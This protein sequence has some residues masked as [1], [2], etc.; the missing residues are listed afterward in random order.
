MS[1]PALALREGGS[2]LDLS[3]KYVSNAFGIGVQIATNSEMTERTAVF[4]LPPVGGVT[5]DCG[6][7]A[8]YVRVGALL[9]DTYHG[10]V[11]YS[12]VYGPAHVIADPRSPPAPGTL[13]LVHTQ[14]I[15]DGVRLHLNTSDPV[16]GILD[17]SE[18]PAGLASKTKTQYVYDR[19]HGF[20]DAMGLV[21][22]RTYSVRLWKTTGTPPFAP[23]LKSIRLD[24][25]Y[26]CE[27][28]L[29]V[30]GRKAKQP[31]RIAATNEF[32]GS[33]RA[34]A[35]VLREA[36]EQPFVRFASNKDYVRYL[37]AKAKSSEE[38]L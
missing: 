27:R 2:T 38:R 11:D 31:T 9:G 30:H 25:V 33:Q 14:A 7:G 16:F 32:I 28:P 5:L 23:E 1:I 20:V 13:A 37:A 19:A 21:P 35:P 36:K 6:G 18:D 12:A 8:W 15:V 24:T 26:E 34:L 17:V 3:W 29:V 10:A 4:L 22:T